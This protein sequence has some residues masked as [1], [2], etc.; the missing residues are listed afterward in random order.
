MQVGET[1]T[2]FAT[3]STLCAVTFNQEGSQNLELLSEAPQ[4]LRSAPETS[5]QNI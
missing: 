5:P 2:N 1:V 3:N 4:L